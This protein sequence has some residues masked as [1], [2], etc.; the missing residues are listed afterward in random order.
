MLLT[1]ELESFLERGVSMMLGTRDADLVPELIRAWGPRIR[2]DRKTISLCVARA[3]GA[4]TLE[5]LRD[6]GRVAVTCALPLNS[7][8]VQLWG[9]CI[10]TGQANRQDLSAVEAHHEAFARTN[11]RIGVPRPFIEALW[12]R[13]LA[14]FPAMIR[15]RFVAEQ[16]FNQTPGPDAGSP[17]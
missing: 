4:R 17:L 8:A 10:G 7:N 13:E 5:N 6:N 2:R 12:Q 1:P 3:G 16:I 9:R 11:E 15:I 14:G